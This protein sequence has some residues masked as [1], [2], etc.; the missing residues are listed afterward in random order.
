VLAGKVALR[1]SEEE[2]A[3]V[4][5]LEEVVRSLGRAEA[6]AVWAFPVGKRGE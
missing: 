6:V 4:P 3:G 1:G 2:V 5:P